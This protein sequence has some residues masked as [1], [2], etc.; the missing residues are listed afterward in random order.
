M[1][2]I[3]ILS[4]SDLAATITSAFKTTPRKKLYVCFGDAPNIFF[5]ILT[6]NN[7]LFIPCIEQYSNPFIKYSLSVSLCDRSTASF[8]IVPCDNAA[9][10][11]PVRVVEKSNTLPFLSTLISFEC[12]PGR[13]YIQFFSPPSSA[14]SPTNS[15]SSPR[16]ISECESSPSDTFIPGIN[17]NG[18]SDISSSLTSH[19]AL[20][21]SSIPDGAEMCGRLYN[22]N[23]DVIIPDA[24]IFSISIPFDFFNKISIASAIAVFR[25]SLLSIPDRAPSESL[26][27]STALPSLIRLILVFVVP[28]SIVI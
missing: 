14:E 28:P 11:S 9:I 27:V 16:I 18:I 25:A 24:R 5:K 19:I 22:P 23:S 12:D 1:P 2:P 10:I 26:I 13:M 20:C 4:S 17:T 3:I 15:V 8:N 6:L 7:A 21:S